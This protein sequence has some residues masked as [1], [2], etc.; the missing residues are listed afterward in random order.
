MAI[1]KIENIRVRSVELL[2]YNV[3]SYMID[4]GYMCDVKQT[5]NGYVTYVFKERFLKNIVGTPS[6]V[7]VEFIQNDEGLSIEIKNSFVEINGLNIIREVAGVATVLPSLNK[8]LDQVKI[9]KSIKKACLLSIE[10]LK[11]SK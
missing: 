5:E 1:A 11:E 4:L 6:C 3:S 7:K 2:A 10:K 9:K 8:I